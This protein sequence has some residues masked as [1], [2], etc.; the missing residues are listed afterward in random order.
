M[1]TTCKGDDH[2]HGAPSGEVHGPRFH[3]GT[4]FG[5]FGSRLS[6]LSG[7]PTVSIERRAATASLDY[8]LTNEMTVGGGAGVGLS[9]V[10]FDGKRRFEVLAGW[11]LM[12]TWSRRLLDGRGNKPFLL[13]SAAFAVSG[14]STRPEPTAVVAPPTAGLYAIDLRGA[15]TVGKT[16]FQTI[17]PYASVRLFGGP[18]FWRY[19]NRAVI[20]G[21]TRHYQL[22]L[23]MTVA[24]PQGV[25][26][27]VD[28]SP[29]GEQAMT[30]GFGKS[31]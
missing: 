26:A 1:V 30:L 4:S 17:S 20:G 7:G 11:L 5:V 8:R 16:F 22:A 24:L 28:G 15:L 14:A 18:V 9:G 3:A 2:D 19:Q 25:D 27:F 31:F 23:G 12:A 13:A 10:F 29:A 21:D 6:F